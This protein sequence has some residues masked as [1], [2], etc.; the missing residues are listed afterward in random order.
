MAKQKQTR[1]YMNL[2]KQARA[3]KLT[4]IAIISLFLM[5]CLTSC[6]NDI[7]TEKISSSDCVMSIV[8][9]GNAL[10]CLSEVDSEIK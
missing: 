10:E 2:G 9:Y 8:T 1:Q 6:A 4:A 7:R 3:A 5:I